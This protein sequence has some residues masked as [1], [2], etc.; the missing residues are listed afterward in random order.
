MMV[1]DLKPEFAGSFHLTTLPSILSGFL[2]LLSWARA[3]LVVRSLSNSQVTSA[4]SSPVCPSGARA[5]IFVPIDL[6]HGQ[7]QYG[8]MA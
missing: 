2:S 6:F 1:V 3:S 5:D 7:G 8:F 4:V